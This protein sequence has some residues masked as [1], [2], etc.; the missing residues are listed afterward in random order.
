VRGARHGRRRA[1]HP[2]DAA[3]GGDG[4]YDRDW[5]PSWRE[6][7]AARIP[8]RLRAR[9]AAAAAAALLALTTGASFHSADEQALGHAGAIA[10]AMA[11]FGSPFSPPPAPMAVAVEEPV[12]QPD[13]GRVV[14]YVTYDDGS[15]ADDGTPDASALLVPAATGNAVWAAAMLAGEAPAVLWRAAGSRPSGRRGVAIPRAQ[16]VSEVRETR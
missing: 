7:A 3:L 8:S 1:R 15:T 13:A 16:L 11:P 14:T 2:A 10:A 4:A 12:F 9:P 6:L 5:A